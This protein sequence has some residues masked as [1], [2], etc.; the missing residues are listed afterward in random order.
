M[1]S[2]I[3]A[4]PFGQAYFAGKFVLHYKRLVRP[5]VILLSGKS[6]NKWRE[7]HTTTLNLIVC[8]VHQYIQLGLVN[9]R[10]PQ[11][12]HIDAGGAKGSAVLTQ[13]ETREDYVVVSMLAKIFTSTEL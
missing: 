6:N 10:L 9:R 11:K 13:G 12:V 4:G 5:L 8:E 7:E 1:Y 2:K 3:V